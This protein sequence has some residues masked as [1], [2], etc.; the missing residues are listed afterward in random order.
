VQAEHPEVLF[1]AEAFTRPK[2]MA[3]LAE[4][5]FSQSY[6][7]FTWRNTKQELTEYVEEISASPLADFMRPNLWPNTPDILDGPLRNGTPAAFRMRALLAA[8]LVPS[9]GIYSGFEL[10][11]NLPQSDANTEYAHSEKFEIRTRDWNDPL[12]LSPFLARLNETRRAHPALQQ[13]R[14]T[15]FHHSSKDALLVYSRATHDLSDV[16]LC[17][18]NLDP[19]TVQ[20]DTL[21]IDL[22]SLGL[23]W[24]GD[25]DA[26]DELTGQL[27]RWNGPNPY[28]RLDP[29][30]APG[31]VLHLKA[32]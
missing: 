11:E 24:S 26:Y 7:Y 13:L 18:V 29:A 31:H 22:G 9:W 21:W 27:F 15:R 23:P 19:A 30:D 2:V 12:S 4:V 6:T 10:C 16:V 5:G 8:T 28:V 32:R 20:E 3:K 1:L 25:I 14:G 17:V